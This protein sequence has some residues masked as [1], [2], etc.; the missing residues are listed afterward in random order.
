MYTYR[1][2]RV[3]SE[4]APKRFYRVM[5]IR[6]DLNLYEI[7]VTVLSVLGAEFEHMFLFKDKLNTYEDESWIE[8]GFG[9]D[10][11]DYRKCYL[12]DL[13]TRSDNSFDLL[14]DTG[15][16]WYFKIKIY[17]KALE[18]KD[19]EFHGMF[20]YV[21]EAKGQCIWEDARYAFMM[22]LAGEKIKSSEKPWNLPK[23][24]GVN[25]FDSD[26]DI[27]KMNERL[28]DLPLLFYELSK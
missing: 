1:K 18:D 14:Y 4:D 21:K 26:V 28:M 13:I 19:N 20:G 12:S 16:G 24:K 8:D 5:Y 3:S 6:E 11:K 2:I 10:A 17:A 15:D 23:N 22:Y 9:Y 7:G 25:Y 27:D